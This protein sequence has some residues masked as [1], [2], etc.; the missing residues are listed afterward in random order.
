MV[1]TNQT[2]NRAT[3]LHSILMSK[4][5]SWP[6]LNILIASMPDSN[7]LKPIV[8][9]MLRMIKPKCPDT[10]KTPQIFYKI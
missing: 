9:S 5:K 6:N 8:R 2:P 10:Q 7:S 4:T 3:P 1:S